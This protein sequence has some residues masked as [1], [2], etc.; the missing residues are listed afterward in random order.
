M[1]INCCICNKLI[2]AFSPNLI[3][4]LKKITFIFF[5]S[6]CCLF[7]RGCPIPIPPAL[8]TPWGLKSLE[9]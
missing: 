4:F 3:G 5:L 8:P 2:Y 1:Y 6:S 7:L 9:G